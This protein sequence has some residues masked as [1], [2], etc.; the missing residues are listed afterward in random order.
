[1]GGLF[2]G[3]PE[4][5]VFDKRSE[6]IVSTIAAQAAIAIDRARLYRAAQEE[7]EH[8]KR[9]EEVLRDNEN[10]RLV[11]PDDPRALAEA[12]L[13]VTRDPAGAVRLARG[14]FETA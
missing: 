14:A 2:F 13:A 9:A 8:R 11:P 12:L 4:P 7:I 1:M 3:H 5:D 10:A 6:R